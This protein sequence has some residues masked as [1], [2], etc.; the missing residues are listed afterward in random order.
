VPACTGCHDAKG[1][2]ALPLIPRLQGQSAAYLYRRLNVFAGPSGA[3]LTALNPM[4]SIAIKL[5]DQERADLAAYFAS[6]PLVDK[7]RPA[8]V[9]QNQH[10]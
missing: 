4:P 7:P 9:A 8:Q 2:A 10:P 3:N 1:E 5:T 6:A